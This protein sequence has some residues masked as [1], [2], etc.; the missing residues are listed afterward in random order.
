VII[1]LVFKGILPASQVF[2]WKKYSLCSKEA[3][4]EELKKD[5]NLLEGNSL[6]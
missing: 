5:V 1:E 4:T 3:C 6:S 2:K